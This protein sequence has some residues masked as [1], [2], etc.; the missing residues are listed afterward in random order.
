M[1]THFGVPHEIIIDQG[2]QFTSKMMR[3]LIEKYGIKHIKY[4]PYHP[5]A[6]GQVEFMNKVLED[7]LTN[8][9]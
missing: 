4:Y 2:T 1:F 6:T 5:Q 9:D 8:T 7:I 3:E